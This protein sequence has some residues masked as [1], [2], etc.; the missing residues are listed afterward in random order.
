ML[1]YKTLKVKV[2]YSLVASEDPVAQTTMMTSAW[3]ARLL[4]EEKMAY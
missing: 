2:G 1:I 3:L 4:N